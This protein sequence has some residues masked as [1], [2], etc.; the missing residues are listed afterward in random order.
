MRAGELDVEADA[1]PDA[2]TDPEADANPDAETDP[3]A[4]AKV[5]VDADTEEEAKVPGRALGGSAAGGVW[6]GKA[7]NGGAYWWLEAA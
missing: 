2:E 7:A 6:R 5:E 1:D 3:E 4:E